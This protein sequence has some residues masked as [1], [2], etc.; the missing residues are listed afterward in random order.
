VDS[1]ESVESI[2]ALLATG[3]VVHALGCGTIL[4]YGFGAFQP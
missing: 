2:P 1:C 3:E 4:I